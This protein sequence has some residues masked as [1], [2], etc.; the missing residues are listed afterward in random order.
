MDQRILIIGAGMAGLFSALALAGPGRR[1][2]VLERD[3]PTPAGGADEAF[4]DWNRRGVG[5]LRHSHA[6]LARLRNLVQDHHPALLDELRDAGCQEMKFADG[7]PAASRD[8]YRPEPGDEILTV[9][10][11]RRTTL[12]MVIR[13]YVERMPGVTIHSNVNVTGLLGDLDADGRFLVEGLRI[14]D[15]EVEREERANIVIDGAGRLS[16]SFDWLAEAGVTWDEESEDAGILYY[17]RHWRLLPDQTPPERGP[18]PGA[19]DMGF[20]KY[21]VFPADNGCFSITLSV[22]EIEET[23]RQAVMRPEIFDHICQLLPGV[24][25]WIAAD[26]SEPVSKVYGMGDLKSRWRSTVKDGKPIALNLF[27]AGDGLARTNPLYGRGC[28]FAAIAAYMIRDALAVSPDPAARA[29]AYQAAVDDGLR[30]Y[31]RAMRDQDR[32]AIR[33][34]RNTLDPTYR[35]RLKAKLMKSFAEDAITPAIRSDPALLRAFMRGFHMLEPSTAWLKRP[36][37]LGSVLGTWITPRALKQKYY[38]PKLGPDRAEMFAALELPAT[39]DA[40]RLGL[41]AA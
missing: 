24:A 8:R 5:H 2:D 40:Q 25:P 4:S 32:Q 10:T 38:P 39:A 20:I 34:A 33:R 16:Q 36:A 27:F 37:T 11:S 6:F 13:R 12:E 17:T 22:P 19:G 41:I 21:G 14:R 30:P 23:L 31:F 29:L 9:I 28:S 7:L 26:R 15:G 35:P 1:V 18:V 3:P